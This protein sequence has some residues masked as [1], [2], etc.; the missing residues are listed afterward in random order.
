[1]ITRAPR[2]RRGRRRRRRRRRSASRRRP[3]RI[4]RRNPATA[5]ACRPSSGRIHLPHTCRTRPRFESPLPSAPMRHRPARRS[6]TRRCISRAAYCR[7]IRITLSRTCIPSCYRII[8]CHR[9]YTRCCAAFIRLTRDYTRPT[10]RTGYT[11]LIRSAMST[12][13]SSATRCSARRMGSRY[14]CAVDAHFFST[15]R[16]FDFISDLLLA[17]TFSHPPSF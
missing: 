16:C 12:A 6:S 2:V 15:L 8:F 5:S 1:M 11:I 10:R 4:R 3:Y 14:I 17:L 9:T 13:A 7:P